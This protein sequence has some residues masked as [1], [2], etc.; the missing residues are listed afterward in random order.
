MP[1]NLPFL[2]TEN[3]GN[4]EMLRFLGTAKTW[5]CFS[6]AKSPTPEPTFENRKTTKRRCSDDLSK[7]S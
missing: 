2:K 3:A 1:Q 4:A 7:Q 5:V 6:G